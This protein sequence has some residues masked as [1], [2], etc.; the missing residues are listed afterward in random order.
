MNCGASRVSAI[1]LAAGS[2]NRFGDRKQFAVVGGR[3]LVDWAVETAAAVCDEVIVVLPAGVEW[4]GPPV[5]AAVLGGRSRSASVRSGLA[6]VSADTNIIVVHDP[7]H[8]L[9]TSSLMKVVITAVR[10]GADAAF[11]AVPL[12][13]PLKQIEGTRVVRTV[14]REGVMMVQS[15][16]AFRADVLRKA[17]VSDPEVV[18]DTM[19]VEA[20]G[21]DIVIVPGDPRNI[22]VTTREELAIVSLL[23]HDEATTG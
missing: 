15:P 4:D 13:E 11:P 3:R 2:G 19:L 21:G 1:I 5:A 9:V 22:H 6:A 18:E 7:A 20:L 10:A 14:P 12:T 23:L 16:H 8:P 17:H